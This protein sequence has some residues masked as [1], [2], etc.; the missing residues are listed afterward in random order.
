MAYRL[1]PPSYLN[2]PEYQRLLED[3]IPPRK[4]KIPR[5]FIDSDDEPI[6]RPKK[7]VRI[8]VNAKKQNPTSVEDLKK[9]LIDKTSFDRITQNHKLSERDKYENLFRSVKD[10]SEKECDKALKNL[11]FKTNFQTE[12]RYVMTTGGLNEKKSLLQMFFLNEIE[13][14]EDKS[15]H[16]K[17]LLSKFS[18]DKDTQE[19]QIALNLVINKQEIQRKQQKF[20]TEMLYGKKGFHKEE[21]EI[22]KN[23]EQLQLHNS[24]KEAGFDSVQHQTQAWTLRQKILQDEI[25]LELLRILPDETEN[26]IRYRLSDN[27]VYKK[28]YQKMSYKELAELD[29]SSGVEQ[30]FEKAYAPKFAVLKAQ[31]KANAKMACP[32]KMCQNTVRNAARVVPHALHYFEYM[33]KNRLF[34]HVRIE[35]LLAQGVPHEKISE[36][37]KDQQNKQKAMD[38]YFV[39]AMGSLTMILDPNNH[40]WHSSW[41][42]EKEAFKHL[43]FYP[44]EGLKHHINSRWTQRIK[45]KKD[46][47]EIK[48]QAKTDIVNFLVA[49]KNWGGHPVSNPA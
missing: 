16:K 38:A 19:D 26:R 4:R 49:S 20:T 42:V 13:R 43:D 36:F 5:A 37:L 47:D 22:P 23:F 14:I 46:K 3:R 44:V 25:P 48:Q 17:V 29:T 15:A 2:D 40:D 34:Y 10:M 9:L 6:R 7:K 27:G 35:T 21:D 8:S 45:S 33:V 30:N 12:Y 32:K 18:S 39:E 24:A 31:A 41:A 1:P 28:A 11:D